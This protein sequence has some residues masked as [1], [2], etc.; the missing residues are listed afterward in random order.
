MWQAHYKNLPNS[1][2][3]SKSKQSVERELHSIKESAIVFRPVDI[4]NAH[5]STKTG[6][7]CGVDGPAAEHFNP[8]SPISHVYYLSMLFNCF[9][10]HG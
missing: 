8:A 7:A 2:D 6:K 3:S 10:T 5:K 4:F 1:V 9:I